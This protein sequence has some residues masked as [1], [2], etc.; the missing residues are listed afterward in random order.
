MIWKLLENLL[1]LAKITGRIPV[2]F[3]LSLSS[4]NID[5]VEKLFHA[6]QFILFMRVPSYTLFLSFSLNLINY[7]LYMGRV[8]GARNCAGP[9]LIIRKTRGNF[10]SKVSHIK[11]GPSFCGARARIVITIIV[12]RS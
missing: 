2:P 5:S 11:G 6:A 7:T 4:L 3:T 12:A 1:D 9:I 8:C 10:P